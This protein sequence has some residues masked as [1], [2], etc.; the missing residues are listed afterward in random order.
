MSCRSHEQ[1]AKVLNLGIWAMA[2][3]HAYHQNPLV[4]P[5]DPRR[6]VAVCRRNDP[7]EASLPLRACLLV[8]AHADLCLPG[9]G[10]RIFESRKH[11][12]ITLADWE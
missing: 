1:Y 5:C 4:S 10:G 8:Q 7:S 3:L 2:L 11:S 6:V 12:T 9:S